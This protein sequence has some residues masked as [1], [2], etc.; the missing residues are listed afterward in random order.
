M[1]AIERS[2]IDWSARL[3]RSKADLNRDEQLFK[4]CSEEVLE[5]SLKILL[6]LCDRRIKLGDWLLSEVDRHHTWRFELFRSIK[7]KSKAENQHLEDFVLDRMALE[8]LNK[9]SPDPRN[10]MHGEAEQLYTKSLECCE[11]LELD[12]DAPLILITMLRCYD[13]LQRICVNDGDNGGSD[14]M[15]RS[16]LGLRKRL[17]SYSNNEEAALREIADGFRDL[18][19][20]SGLDSVIGHRLD[21][22]QMKRIHSDLTEAQSIYRDLVKFRPYSVENV[23]E[24]IETTINMIEH[25]PPAKGTI[26]HHQQL[27]MG[28]EAAAAANTLLE[29]NTK[30][31]ELE[32]LVAN[33][34]ATLAALEQST[35]PA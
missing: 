33:L 20:T 26:E 29:N 14:E 13:G 21:P 9:R 17:L 2:S 27:T 32:T 10:E 15:A 16:A 25:F 8:E 11:A 35:D 22:E 6:D 31:V 18:V 23:V 34:L 30:T 3:Q 1:D 12:H 19:W 7:A 28:E 5:S 24:L 4:S